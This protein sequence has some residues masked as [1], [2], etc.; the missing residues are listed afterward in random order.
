MGEISLQYL[1]LP[2]HN[3]NSGVKKN[4]FLCILSWNKNQFLLKK[5]MIQD[6]KSLKETKT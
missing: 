4:L 3:S 5:K 1:S 2:F 6:P